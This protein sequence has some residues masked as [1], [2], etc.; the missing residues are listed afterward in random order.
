MKQLVN[1]CEEDIIRNRY[2]F[3]CDSYAKSLHGELVTFSMGEEIRFHTSAST[4]IVNEYHDKNMSTYSTS[5]SFS[6]QNMF[7]LGDSQMAGGIEQAPASVILSTSTKY[8]TARPLGVQP[9]GKE[10][11]ATFQ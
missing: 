3:N 1:Y 10:N 5:M 9:C 11:N 4:E 2:S 8:S 7:L 6:G